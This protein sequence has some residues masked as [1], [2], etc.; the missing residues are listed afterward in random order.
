MLHFIQFYHILKSFFFQDLF[1]IFHIAED[2]VGGTVIT[3][4]TFSAIDIELW[5]L[6]NFPWLLKPSSVYS[7]QL[8]V[9]S[10]KFLSSY[11]LSHRFIL[12]LLILRI[13]IFSLC[14]FYVAFNHHVKFN[15]S[16]LKAS[17]SF[18]QGTFQPQI[19][20]MINVS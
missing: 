16:V 2:K 19:S 18:L 3:S 7:S 14:L 1:K 17:N 5:S 15:H 12:L 13:V 4:F 6:F 8:I 20:F 10:P 9:L 11:S